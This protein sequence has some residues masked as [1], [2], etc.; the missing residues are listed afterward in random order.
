M[1]CSARL[2][3]DGIIAPSDTRSV[4]GLGLA[5]AMKSWD[6]QK[7]DKGNFGVFRF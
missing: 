3:D 5:V 1:F 7:R 6:V 4:L 2:M